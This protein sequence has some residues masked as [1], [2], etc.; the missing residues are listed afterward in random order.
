M[1]VLIFDLETD[2][3]LHPWSKKGA[4]V[5]TKIHCMGVVDLDGN[6]HLFVASKGE[7]AAGLDMLN[8]ADML[9]GHN[10]QGF[11]LRVLKKLCGWVPKAGT[12]VFD[13]V[14]AASCI[15][16]DIKKDDYRLA[17][18][19]PFDAVPKALRGR[20]S[21]ESWG[22][23]LGLLKGAYGKDR[24]DWSNYS[25]D[26][27]TYCLGDCLVTKKLYQLL[28]SKHPSEH[29]L[30]LEHAF[31]N[32]IDL[33]QEIGVTFNDQKARELYSEMLIEKAQ[34][35]KDLR[36]LFPPR[37]VEYF[38]PVKKL[39]KEK[40]IP[41]N[42][43]S[44]PQIIW[45][46]K[47]KYGWKPT[48]YTEDSDDGTPKMDETVLLGLPYAEAKPLARY[49][50]LTKLMG[51]LGSPNN[52]WLVLQQADKAIHGA[53][54]T[55]GT[56][57]GRVAPFSPNLTQVPH[58]CGK[59]HATP[60]RT[61]DPNHSPYGYEIRSLFTPR[62]GWKMIGC[63]AKGIQLRMLAHFMAPYDGGEYIRLV[64]TGDP[65]EAN[66]VAAG[67]E[68]RDQAKTFIYALLFGAGDGKIGKITGK[69]MVEGRKT[70]A[71]FFAN[72][73]AFARLKAGIEKALR[74][75]GFLRGL[76][77][78]KYPIRSK[79][80]ALNVLL[81]GGEAVVMKTATLYFHSEMARRGYNLREDYNQILFIHDEFQFEARPEIADEVGQVAAD[82]ITRAGA[83][84]RVRCPLAGDFST[85]ANWAE[86]H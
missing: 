18:L 84:L 49:L 36:N 23:R 33:Q 12:K 45:H 52:G 15:Y 37:I 25:D 21:L 41:F 80:V 29:M 39:R 7:L 27:G 83:D 75:N 3:L 38:T 68:T 13:T 53:M 4:S 69:G 64:T 50:Q 35:N 62:P 71:R 65:H 76:D 74:I 85:G 6:K 82:A 9:V 16:P 72:M 70:K 11:D 40:T 56:V 10:V 60:C 32:V 5:V 8:E 77:G 54:R 48:V 30:S 22:Y 55:N 26:M 43:N 20:H 58:V 61:F 78:R 2:G 79:H 73:P 51:Y 34:L 19:R 67:L 42:P 24:K 63:D 59:C 46:L 66:R 14:I 81:M 47:N 28:V 86:T 1:R 31:A 44:R 57:T 17:H